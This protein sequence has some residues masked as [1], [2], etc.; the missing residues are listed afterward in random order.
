MDEFELGFGNEP[1]CAGE[2]RTSLGGKVGRKLQKGPYRHFL[3]A[4]LSSR[5]CDWPHL[6]AIYGL[7]G[8]SLAKMVREV[9]LAIPHLKRYL[10]GRFQ[11]VCLTRVK[12]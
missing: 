6:Q 1:V 7:A 9:D 3:C 12:L 8:L 4:D 10:A 2:Q 5:A 11:S